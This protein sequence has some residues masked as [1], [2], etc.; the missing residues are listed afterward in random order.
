MI[1]FTNEKLGVFEKMIKPPEDRK[2][3]MKYYKK[4]CIVDDNGKANY[5]KNQIFIEGGN[6]ETSKQL[7]SGYLYYDENKK[8]W[9]RTTNP[10]N[11]LTTLF[12]NFI[13][14][15]LTQQGG[16]KVRQFISSCGEYIF[17]VIYCSYLNLKVQASISSLNK[18][19]SYCQT[20]I[21]SLEPT[22]SRLRPLRLNNI[23]KINQ[24]N[25]N[26]KKVLEELKNQR[27][28]ERF[29]KE[30]EPL[31]NSFLLTN[32]EEFLEQKQNKIK[33]QYQ[34]D[35][36]EYKYQK[37]RTVF[38]E[39]I[40]TLKENIRK[41]V[42]EELNNQS[43]S[44]V[45]GKSS[46]SDQK[47]DQELENL[48]IEIFKLLYSINL[49]KL[50]FETQSQQIKQ[51]IQFKMQ[52]QLEKAFIS[53]LEESKKKQFGNNIKTIW[54]KYNI[55]YSPIYTEYLYTSQKQKV[56]NRIKYENLWNKKVINIDEKYD[57]FTK[58]QRIKITYSILVRLFDFSKLKN[59]YNLIH[60]YFPLHDQFMLTGNDIYCEMFYQAW[61][62]QKKQ[63][64]LLKYDLD[65]H[66]LEENGESIKLIKNKIFSEEI[67]KKE[68]EQKRDLFK[69]NCLLQIWKGTFNYYDIPQ[70]EIRDY[71][72]EKIALYF[73]FLTFYIK[74]TLPI[75]FLALP[76]FI[77]QELN[78]GSSDENE[79]DGLLEQSFS[80]IFTLIVVLWA[81][82]FCGQWKLIETQ[83]VLKYGMQDIDDDDNIR[84]GFKGQYVRSI[85][86]NKLNELSYDKNETL[87]IEFLTW[88]IIF[89][90]MIVNTIIIYALLY[91]QV[92]F[93]KYNKIDQGKSFQAL[94]ILVP[95]LIL[96]L[97][98]SIFEYFYHF[99]IGKS[100]E[101]ANYKTSQ[102]YEDSYSS[103]IFI[104]T[105]FNHLIPPTL[106]SFII[107]L[108]IR[109]VQADCM[110]HLKGYV[111]SY[112]YY[113]ILKQLKDCAMPLFYRF[114]I[115]AKEINITIRRNLGLSSTQ[116]INE[117]TKIN[118]QIETESRQS[119]I[120]L[121]K[122]QLFINIKKRIK[123]KRIN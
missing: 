64:F 42:T 72:G 19:L 3:N 11:D 54:D 82:I 14:Y 66:K 85:I 98:Y 110:F 113:L 104:I 10:V 48:K 22:D 106:I 63:E 80:I 45:L 7:N 114:Y 17:L 79:D 52:Q 93:D 87:K 57:L 122:I 41:Q 30:I 120:F 103:K 43:Q 111:R 13:I 102:E 94:N 108:N 112:Q 34:A 100:C 39:T 37:K 16:F 68:F 74:F 75:A 60:N 90:V 1:K 23:I 51:F 117:N 105:L 4:N 59:K 26:V 53:S 18:Q 56:R 76:V 109:C 31:E 27:I 33:Y 95:T 58:M 116:I 50:S 69:K 123:Y 5:L 88:A 46:Q 101:L 97:I 86:S 24:E 21:F 115:F 89:I 36:L 35:E 32:Y 2:A 8:Q 118:N 9:L 77:I 73:T 25:E 71:F 78:I 44:I 121:Y 47:E 15:K 67:Y 40:E 119:Y 12:R 91:L 107:N 61:L 92:F 20:D 81:N 29:T 55:K 84:P 62:N 49:K 65:D 83:F 28:K 38:L 70:K 6:G 96:Q 99:L